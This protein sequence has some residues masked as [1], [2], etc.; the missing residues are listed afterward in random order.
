MRR[1]SHAAN[2][3]IELTLKQQRRSRTRSKV[4]IAFEMIDVDF[5]RVCVI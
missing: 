5:Q 3:Y 1:A 4:A 2:G